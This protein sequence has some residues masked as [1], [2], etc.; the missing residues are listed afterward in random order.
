MEKFFYPQSIVIIG[1]SAKR[2]NIARLI[3][4][5]L[6]RWGYCGRIFGLN[7]KSEEAHVTGIRIYQN[8]ED[9]PE[10]PDLAVCFVP[11]R[12]V[13]GYME[14]CGKFG[15]KN[16]A[17]PS[18]GFAE[19]NEEGKKMSEDLIAIAK[20]YGIRF[21]GPNGLMTANTSNGLCIPFLPLFQPPAGRLSLIS[22]SGGLGLM[23]W[24]LLTNENVGLA[25]FASIG[26][27]LDID[28]VD[29]LEYLDQDPDTGIICM[30]LESVADGTR[31]IEAA[32]KATKPIV[33]Y[34]SNTTSAGKKAAYSHTAALSNDEDTIDAAFEDAGI[35]RI[36][37]YSDFISVAKAFELPPMRGNR[38]MI[39]SP[40]GG[41]SVVSA[42]LCE[43]AGLEFA[44]P[45]QEFYEGL[46]KFTN[47]GVIKFSN[48]LDT[49]DI[50]DPYIVAHV[51]YEVLHNENVD[52][53]IYIGQTGRAPE[54]DNV[55]TNYLSA[56][57]SKDVY[58]AMLSSGK[59]LAICLYGRVDPLLKTKHNVNY[60]IFN[61]PEEMVR[62]LV[63]QKD[64]YARMAGGPSKAGAKP[65]FDKETVRKWLDI[66]RGETGEESL[67]LLRIAGLP[68][69]ET[70]VA[71]D[72]KS[73]VSIAEKIGYPVVMKVVSPDAPH[74]SEVGGVVL[75]VKDSEGV[76]SGFQQ[77]KNN[78]ENYRKGAR[79]EGVRIQK[80]ADDGYD[81][82]IGGKFDMSFGPVVL[83]GLGGIYVETFKDIRIGLCP[84]DSESVRK[85][86]ESLKSFPIINGARGMKPADIKGFVDAIIRISWLLSDFSEIKELDIN[87]LRLLAD[88]TAV[89]ALD[90][91]MV[92]KK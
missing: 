6:L 39:M 12:L 57:V 30:Y 25:K 49:G 72:E 5:N 65:D 38:V 74:K 28:E 8:M 88:G 67:E 71:A 22:Q 35:I 60:P 63:F 26:N 70:E 16:V 56:D 84:A 47:A 13:P 11:A 17:V 14:A 34:K 85:K 81:M 89:T 40:Y 51:G 1:L 19:L 9:L 68:V 78:L 43:K 31:L 62:A 3:L 83:F 2:G 46:A 52:G 59:P 77:I 75:G 48:P 41:F 42:D 20:K 87:P 36:S 29:V 53:A 91:R 4:E 10:V 69:P 50:Y 90:A 21:M 58:G 32:K 44:D 33:I 15:I 37:D 61:S 55:F 66:H 82:Y 18:G 80:M 76:K 73:A 7:P 86:I 23:L 92:V 54:G 79:F 64:W 45:G 24:H 27:K